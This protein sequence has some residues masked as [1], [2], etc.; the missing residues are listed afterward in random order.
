M[1]QH[2]S[3]LNRDGAWVPMSLSYPPPHSPATVSSLVSA[4]VSW[5]QRCELRWRSGPEMHLWKDFQQLSN[6]LSGPGP[7]LGCIRI[8][9]SL[10]FAVNWDEMTGE[11]HPWQLWTGEPWLTS[12]QDL[13]RLCW[14]SS[15]KSSH[16]DNTFMVG[17]WST[18]CMSWLWLRNRKCCL[19]MWKSM[20][21][22]QTLKPLMQ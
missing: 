4:L 3:T 1:A 8:T 19:Q 7:S 6:T 10:H 15:A 16:L 13:I 12:G 11:R 5:V 21:K 2:H 20:R 17:A 9:H 14:C 22:K 18:L